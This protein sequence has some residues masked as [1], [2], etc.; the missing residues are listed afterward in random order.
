MT[1][2]RS[3]TALK[4]RTAGSLGGGKRVGGDRGED[5]GVQGTDVIARVSSALRLFILGMFL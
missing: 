3:L 4:P 5:R 2:A 1:E